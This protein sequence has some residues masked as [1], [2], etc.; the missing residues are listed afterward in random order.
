MPAVEDYSRLGDMG[1][2]LSTCTTLNVF[3][4]GFEMRLTD[5]R[6]S[7]DRRR[8]WRL[9]GFPVWAVFTT[10]TSGAKRRRDRSSA[11]EAKHYGADK[12]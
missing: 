9:L 7:L 6:S 4:L 12:F 10:A 5:G 1:V 3:T 2:L 11:A 8:V